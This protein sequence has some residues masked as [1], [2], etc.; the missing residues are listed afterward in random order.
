[1]LAIEWTQGIEDA[2]SD[3]AQFVPKLVGALVILLI[4]WFIAKMIFR[5]AVRV[6]SKV[7]FDRLV[8][9]GGLGVHLERA[10]YPD[11]GVLLAKIIYW[12]AMLIVFQMAIGVFGDSAV[13]DAFESIL[14]FLPK[15]FIAL[16]IVVI[17]GAI[18][19]RVGEIVRNALVDHEYAQTVATF[20]TGS[21]WL[22][23]IFAALNQVEIAQDIVD[24]LFEAITAAITG[25]LIIKFGVGGIW[26]A[27]D[28]FWPKVYDKFEGK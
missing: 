7:G 27:R 18:A 25:I 6:L 20:A 24:T 4:G 19:T 15:L 5:I 22:I 26:A 17:T 2:W 16:V 1:M 28:R 21:I 9:R 23:G 10:G 11:S 14:A 12:G 3:V 13:Q 8:D